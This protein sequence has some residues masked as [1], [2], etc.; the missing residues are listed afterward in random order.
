MNR[1]MSRD[2]PKLLTSS[3]ALHNAMMRLAIAIEW[4]M[5]EHTD[6]KIRLMCSP[7]PQSP[8]AK[9]FGRAEYAMRLQTVVFSPPALGD[10]SV[11]N[12]LG[13]SS[14]RR[15]SR[16]TSR[17]KRNACR[18]IGMH[19]AQGANK[20]EFSYQQHNHRISSRAK[21]GKGLEQ[22]SS[23]KL[24]AE[25]K[26]HSAECAMES[27]PRVGL[28]TG[29]GECQVITTLPCHSARRRQTT[30][31]RCRQPLSTVAC[32]GLHRRRGTRPGGATSLLTNSFRR[33]R[34]GCRLGLVRRC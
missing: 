24:S 22:L 13:S 7:G 23:S 31:T 32:S 26:R 27:H 20:H 21:A 30:E 3:R 11:P 34:Q 5:R 25:R 8:M 2:R 33:N 9:S 12:D 1:R 14:S 29:E 17:A 4:H 28:I 10:L 6:G 18:Q 15:H 19:D 16:Q